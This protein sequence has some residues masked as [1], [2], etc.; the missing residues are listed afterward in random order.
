LSG[1]I[2]LC[3]IFIYDYDQKKGGPVTIQLT[4]P[5]TASEPHLLTDTYKQNNLDY[6]FAEKLKAEKER[7]GLVFSP[8]AQLNSFFSSPLELTLLSTTSPEHDNNTGK[9]HEPAKTDL[10]QSDAP[11]PSQAHSANTRS[12][13]VFEPGGTLQFNRQLIQEL[14]NKTNLL[15]PNLAAQPLFSQAFEAGALQPK[16]D[17]QALIDKILE[18]VNLVKSKG[19]IELS[20]NLRQEDLGDIFLQLTSL[21]GKVSIFM[22][23]GAETKKLI[24]AHKDELERALKKAHVNFDTVTIE[25]VKKPC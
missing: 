7:I 11:R 13:E 19:K 9:T 20:L 4:A 15:V 24:D 5:E 2:D 16:L 8:F 12:A 14:L 3:K 10:A 1:L 23:A 17:L 18:Q 21:S 25:E 6:S 22:S